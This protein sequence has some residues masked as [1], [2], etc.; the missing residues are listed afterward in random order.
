MH[1]KCLVP[2]F[3]TKVLT[4]IND[5]IIGMHNMLN[6]T[7]SSIYN[8][9]HQDGIMMTTTKCSIDYL[10]KFLNQIPSAK[11]CDDYYTIIDTVNNNGEDIFLLE[12]KAIV[13]DTINILGEIYN[14]KN[15]GS[16]LYTT[17]SLNNSVN[18]LGL[19]NCSA[20]SVISSLQHWMVSQMPTTTST[21]EVSMITDFTLDDHSDDNNW[22]IKEIDIFGT[23]LPVWSIITAAT[24]GIG[25]ICTGIGYVIGQYLARNNSCEDI[26]AKH[27]FSYLIGDK[28]I[29]DIAQTGFVEPY[30][31]MPLTGYN[32]DMTDD[33]SQSV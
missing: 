5:Y 26:T 31:I 25:L 18:F 19:K 29:I 14:M 17:L 13:N 3:H 24:T 20:G 22:L 23:K 9:Q 11:L 16:E 4:K 27:E 1:L 15:S 30:A 21:T 6:N 10:Y 32:N 8:P 12:P 7:L 33:V 28:A 2:L